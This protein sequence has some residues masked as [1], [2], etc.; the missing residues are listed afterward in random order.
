[1]L[2]DITQWCFYVFMEFMAEAGNILKHCQR[3]EISS[4]DAIFQ[5]KNTVL[6]PENYKK[7][8]ENLSFKHDIQINVEFQYI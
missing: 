2:P 3:A 7:S 1:M 5:A 4:N 6:L 8:N